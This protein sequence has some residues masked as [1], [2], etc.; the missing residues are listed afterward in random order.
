MLFFPL[1][2]EQLAAIEEEGVVAHPLVAAIKELAAFDFR[3]L[4]RFGLG[5]GSSAEEEAF[6]FAK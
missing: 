1:G 6:V 3:C 2:G 5:F 4:V